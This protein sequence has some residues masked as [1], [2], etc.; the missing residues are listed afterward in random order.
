MDRAKNHFSDG[1]FE[2][3]DEGTQVPLELPLLSALES[4]PGIG[5][6]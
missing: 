4:R 5:H 2:W 3:R 1:A 6:R